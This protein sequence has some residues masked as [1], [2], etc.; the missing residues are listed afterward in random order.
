MKK[1]IF[2]LL[3]LVSCSNKPVSVIPVRTDST[4]IIKSNC[5]SVT[6]V[7]DNKIKVLNDSIKKLNERPLMTLEQFRIIY[8]YDRLYKYYKICEHN[9]SQWKYYKG[10]SMRVFEN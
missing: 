5:D 10:W 4:I 7:Y 1:L 9:S 2:L 6:V 3:I 8:K